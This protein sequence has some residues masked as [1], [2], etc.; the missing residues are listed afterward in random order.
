MIA[1]FQR[2]LQKIYVIA[3][4]I[5][6]TVVAVPA[7]AAPFPGSAG[8]ILTNP[9]FG[10]FF[11]VRGFSLTTEGTTWLPDTTGAEGLLPEKEAVRLLESISFKSSR[12]K[13]ARLSV[14]VESLK[15][16]TTLERYSRRF[17]RDFHQYGFELLR[18]KPIKLNGHLG[19]VYDLKT[20][21]KNLRLRQVVFLKERSAVTLTCL[22]ASSSFENSIK[23]CDQTIRQFR[24]LAAA[25]TPSS[26]SESPGKN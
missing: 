2:R 9:E 5:I 22:D 26:T 19:V 17:V 1:V 6:G 24:W 16:K 23:E 13:Q 10:L 7:L 12:F 25:S 11:L 18:T 4:I 20:R 8:S 21:Q 3:A 14:H 15:Q